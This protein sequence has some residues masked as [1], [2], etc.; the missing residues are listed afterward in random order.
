[1]L[2]KSWGVEKICQDS[3]NNQSL[4]LKMLEWSNSSSL[5]KILK[6]G[7]SLIIWFL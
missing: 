7:D 5:D 2:K 1:M 4:A 3:L 6:F